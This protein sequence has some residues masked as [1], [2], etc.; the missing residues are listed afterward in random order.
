MLVLRVPSL[1]L[2]FRGGNQDAA[3]PAGDRRGGVCETYL[4]QSHDVL[5]SRVIMITAALARH[6]SLNCHHLPERELAVGNHPAH[7][8]LGVAVYF[9]W[10]HLQSTT[11][12]VG[13]GWPNLF[14]R[15]NPQALNP[16]PLH[17]NPELNSKPATPM[18]RFES[19]PKLFG[20]GGG[21]A[22]MYSKKLQRTPCI[23]I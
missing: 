6:C 23:P 20:G 12:I 19:R 9:L 7:T 16:K 10:L 17:G 4:R 15:P 8:H 18:P 22:T 11:L 1:G 5:L 13:F 14:N 21:G 3:A 2:I